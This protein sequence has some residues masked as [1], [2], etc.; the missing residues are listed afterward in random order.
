MADAAIADKAQL[1]NT[2]RLRYSVSTVRQGKHVFYTLTMPSE[3]L[4]RTCMVST[5]KEDPKLGFQRELD[6][7]RAAEIAHYIDNDVGTIPSS[8]VLLA[9]EEAFLKIV[10]K[11]KT[12][13]FNNTLRAF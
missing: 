3:V 4:S 13:E 6:E 11:G 10:G 8:I 12:L 5:R 7:K 2:E 9:Q 1:Q